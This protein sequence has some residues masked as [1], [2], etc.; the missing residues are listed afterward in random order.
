MFSAERRAIATLFAAYAGQGLRG[1]RLIAHV[2][3]ERPDA[4]WQD[5]MCAAF[6]AVTR[7]DA[8]QA[9]VPI[10]YDVALLLRKAHN[11]ET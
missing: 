11:N 1:A 7:R 3:D 9:T 4:T 8:D 6:L 5:L 10:I 2:R